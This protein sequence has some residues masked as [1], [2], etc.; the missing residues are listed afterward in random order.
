MPCWVLQLYLVVVAE[1]ANKTP[2]KKY[3]ASTRRKPNQIP[4]PSA[5]QPQAPVYATPKQEMH[6][7]IY[8]QANEQKCS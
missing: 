4:P 7:Y 6:Q 8:T 2:T 3:E 5:T 1:K